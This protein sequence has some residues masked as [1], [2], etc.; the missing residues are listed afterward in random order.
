ME[1]TNNATGTK[2]MIQDFQKVKKN[3]A[4]EDIEPH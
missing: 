3:D 1:N 4:V 2:R